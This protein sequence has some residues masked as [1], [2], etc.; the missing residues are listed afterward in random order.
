MASIRWSTNVME[1]ETIDIIIVFISQELSEIK[2]K[3]FKTTEKEKD[4]SNCMSNEN[5]ITKRCKKPLKYRLFR[6][7]S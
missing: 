4:N 2:K 3:T 7:F 5:S 6:V 1:F